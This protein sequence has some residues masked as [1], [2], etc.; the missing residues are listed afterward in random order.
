MSFVELVA[1]MI[2]F[3][4]H[5]EREDNRVSRVL[6]NTTYIKK[7]GELYSLFVLNECS[8]N[9]SECLNL[10]ANKDESVCRVENGFQGQTTA[11]LKRSI[12]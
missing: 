6:E 11:E 1:R 8:R 2:E 10:K 9:L 4:N 7:I 3:E 12:L 5:S